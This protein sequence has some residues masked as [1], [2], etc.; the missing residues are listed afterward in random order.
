[1]TVHLAKLGDICEINPRLPR[2]HGL[3]DDSEVSFVPMAA[4]SEVSEPFG[5][6]RFDAT[7]R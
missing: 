5:R 2:E 7:P 4:V 1:M 6:P 3:K